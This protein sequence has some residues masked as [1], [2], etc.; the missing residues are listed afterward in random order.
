MQSIEEYD[1]LEERIIKNLERKYHLIPRQTLWNFVAGAF[2]S[3]TAFIIAVGFTSWLATAKVFIEPQVAKNVRTIENAA[4]QLEEGLPLSRLQRLENSTTLLA[5]WV[6][7][8]FTVHLGKM[9]DRDWILDAEKRSSVLV[10][11]LRGQN[12]GWGLLNTEIQTESR[13]Q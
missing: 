13:R 9:N 6:N 7:A 4:K 5:A 2:F 12:P 1:S 8:S 11:R 10:D 3:V